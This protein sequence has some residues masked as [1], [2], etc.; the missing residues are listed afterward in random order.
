MVAELTM[1][2]QQDGN[3]GIQFGS[4]KFQKHRNHKSMARGKEHSLNIIAKS[5]NKPGTQGS[6][7]TIRT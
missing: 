3:K 2:V 6:P 5:S 1:K 7:I 4:L